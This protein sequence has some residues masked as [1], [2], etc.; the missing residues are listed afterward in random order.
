VG[1]TGARYHCDAFPR[2]IARVRENVG[3]ADGTER[4]GDG[5]TPKKGWVKFRLVHSYHRRGQ[6]DR[7]LFLVLVKIPI[8]D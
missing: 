8:D 1:S 7:S 6:G 5:D 2:K 4:I 3:S